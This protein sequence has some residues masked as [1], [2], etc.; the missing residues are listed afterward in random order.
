MDKVKEYVQEVLMHLDNGDFMSSY[1]L[2]ESNVRPMIDEL[3]QDDEFVK[4]LIQQRSN[5]DNEDWATTIEFA[6]EIKKALND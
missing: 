2:F 5:I 1:S 3:D 4:M 6:E